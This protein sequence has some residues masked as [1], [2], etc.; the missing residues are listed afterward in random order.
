MTAR[1]TQLDNLSALNAECLSCRPTLYKIA[2]LQ[3]RDHTAAEDVVQETLLAAIE[4][5]A[6]FQGRSSIR[7][8][9]LGILRFKIIDSL[10]ARALGA[11]SKAV[12]EESDLSDFDAMFDEDGNWAEPKSHWRSPEEQ[13]EEVEFFRVLELCMERLPGNT[14]RVFMMRE[15][16]ELDTPEI[17]D[18]ARLSSG[19]VRAL[20]YRARMTLRACLNKNWYD[21]EE[22]NDFRIRGRSL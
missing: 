3:L 6:A 15:F 9:L 2:L 11:L 18:K 19:N 4:G 12:D 7:T 20:L 21:A 14:A 17:C 22:S 13:C 16:L 8:W 5:G 10:R 1:A